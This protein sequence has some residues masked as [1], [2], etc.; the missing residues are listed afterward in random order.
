MR[1]LFFVRSV[2]RECTVVSL[3]LGE[4]VACGVRDGL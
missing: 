2:F 4:M 1:R 3:G